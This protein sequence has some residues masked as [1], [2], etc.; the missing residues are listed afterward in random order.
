MKSTAM[1]GVL[2]LLLVLLASW[3]SAGAAES[4][5]LRQTAAALRAGA[6]ESSRHRRIRRHDDKDDKDDK[7]DDEDDDEDDDDDDGKEDAAVETDPIR[8]AVVKTH[9]ALYENLKRRVKVRME[10]RELGQDL[11]PEHSPKDIQES[12]KAVANETGSASLS[13]FVGDMWKD[14]RMFAT[15]YY[16]DTLQK[17]L[18]HL[19]REHPVLEAAYQKAKSAGDAEDKPGASSA[20]PAAAP[21]A[22][23]GA[24][25]Q[26]PE[27]AH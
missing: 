17:E 21:A 15:P 3:L 26:K 2:R 25:E 9:T 24:V 11:D 12:V 8:I 13:S 6:S 22:S 20:A 18:D 16:R 19:E 5:A 10:I 7:D 14:M 1:A 23:A 4:R 27:E